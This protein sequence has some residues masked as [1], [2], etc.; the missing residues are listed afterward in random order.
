M[1]T[2]LFSGCALPRPVRRRRV[3]EWRAYGAPAL[4]CDGPPQPLVRRHLTGSASDVSFTADVMGSLKVG[5]GTASFSQQMPPCEAACFT[6]VIARHLA[7]LEHNSEHSPAPFT[8]NPVV[9]TSL[10]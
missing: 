6:K 7:S 9:A 8:W 3:V 5:G 2:L 1:R 10:P 4:P